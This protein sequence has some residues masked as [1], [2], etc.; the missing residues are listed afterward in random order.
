MGKEV[1]TL[2]ITDKA[3]KLLMLERIRTGVPANR[4]VEILIEKEVANAK[5]DL[6]RDATA[7]G[8]AKETT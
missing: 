8:V 4:Q 6:Q 5:V 1:K 3:H 2:R 7:S